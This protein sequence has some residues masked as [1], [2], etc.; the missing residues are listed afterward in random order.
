MNANKLTNT[1]NEEL[2]NLIAEE[3]AGEAA[4]DCGE[5]TEDDVKAEFQ[6]TLRELVKNETAVGDVIRRA[7]DELDHLETNELAET[8][9]EWGIEAGVD[10]KY[11]KELV[12]RHLC[13]AGK[14]RRKKGAGRKAK[15][16]ESKLQKLAAFAAELFAAEAKGALR[17]AQAFVESK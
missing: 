15:F 1:N 14:R 9:V 16:D 17:A 4:E 5:G 6:H 3:L 13:A 8:L 10:E 12:S 11:V 2:A 7:A